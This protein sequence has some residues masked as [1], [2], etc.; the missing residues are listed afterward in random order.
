MT[1]WYEWKVKC[2]T[3]SGWYTVITKDK[4]PPI[5][6]PDNSAHGVVSG[7]EYII[8]WLSNINPQ[9]DDIN[10]DSRL[11]VSPGLFP[12]YMNP[13]FTSEG[14]DTTNGRRG[15][16]GRLVMSHADGASTTNETIIQFVDYIQILGGRIR[17]VGANPD[18]YISF[19]CYVDATPVVVNDMTV[20]N[21]NLYDIGGG[22]NMIIPAE[23]NGTHDVD[24]TAAINVNVAGNPGQP[25][26][27]TQAIPVPATEEDGTSKGHFD[28]NRI[29]GAVTANPGRGKYYLFNFPMVLSRYVNKICVYSGTETFDHDL[30]IFH[31]GG[32]FLPHWKCKIYTTRASSHEPSDPPVVYNFI[33][34]IARKSST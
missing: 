30:S 21:C 8:A 27:I 4:M 12:D 3:D 15:E 22:A 17:V 34:N 26:L 6:C 9:L 11:K 24:L 25:T 20:G 10:D 29:T 16:G 19:D 7:Q 2:A 31:R 18:D 1:S 33:L 13:Y 14:D 23:G 32:P 28:W 5:N